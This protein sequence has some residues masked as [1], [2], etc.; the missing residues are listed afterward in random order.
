MEAVPQAQ[1]VALELRHLLLAHRSQGLAVEVGS[2]HRLAARAKMVV[3]TGARTQAALPLHLEAQ[4]QAVA[5]VVEA[6]N[7]G[8]EQ[9]EQ[10]AQALW[11]SNTQTR[12][13]SPTPAVV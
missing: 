13:P 6:N 9:V 7:L 11:F 2:A 5:G 3:E 1:T 10:A 4:T 12:S 8:I